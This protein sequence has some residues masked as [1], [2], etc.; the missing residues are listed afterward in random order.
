M[1]DLNL[2]RLNAM[3]FKPGAKIEVLRNQWPFPYHVRVGSTEY[4][5]RRSLYPAVL[6][7]TSND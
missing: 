2:P 1:T 3:G 7:V 5:V 6:A 4:M